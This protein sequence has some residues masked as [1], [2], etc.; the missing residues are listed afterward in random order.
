MT[1]KLIGEIAR[2]LGFHYYDKP[3]RVY[4][5]DD[6]GHAIAPNDGRVKVSETTLVVPHDETHKPKDS[7]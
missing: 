4:I 3:D 6:K 1:L 5:K 7:S 2:G